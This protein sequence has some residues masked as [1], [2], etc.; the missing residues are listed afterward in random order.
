MLSTAVVSGFNRQMGNRASSRRS[1]HGKGCRSLTSW[2][3]MDSYRGIPS[4]PRMCFCPVQR[5]A[6]RQPRRVWHRGTPRA[7]P[8]TVASS[9]QFNQRRRRR[10]LSRS[11]RST[12]GRI[13]EA[14]LSPSG[15]T[16]LMMATVRRNQRTPVSEMQRL[17]EK[18][19]PLP[20]NLGAIDRRALLTT[21][22]PAE[23][24]HMWRAQRSTRLQRGPRS[25]QKST[26]RSDRLDSAFERLW[27]TSSASKLLAMRVPFQAC[28]CF[29]ARS[30]G[31]LVVC[32]AEESSAWRRTK[33]SSF[34]LKAFSRARA[35]SWISEDRSTTRTL[36]PRSSKSGFARC[37]FACCP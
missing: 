10:S 1:T 18:S 22:A 32:A 9:A 19:R 24:R 12:P 6:L 33:T 29:S 15:R 11:L 35:P 25:L 27:S 34:T 20:S 7:A 4:H 37:L 16:L 28:W 21:V 30:C 13:E 14:V 23:G 36:R 26:C 3:M 17:L 5:R 31:G 2:E 8:T